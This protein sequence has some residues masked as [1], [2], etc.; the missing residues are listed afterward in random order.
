MIHTDVGNLQRKDHIIKSPLLYLPL[1]KYYFQGHIKI[2]TECKEN[3]D[4]IKDQD[5]LLE[6][7][8]KYH[9]ETPI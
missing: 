1:Q 2:I 3:N 6:T 7:V 9:L 8:E 4:E 5:D